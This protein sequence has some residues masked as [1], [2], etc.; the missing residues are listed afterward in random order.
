MQLPGPLLLLIGLLIRC[1]E[2][3]VK[4]QRA[5]LH[6]ATTAALNRSARLWLP[7]GP[8]MPLQCIDVRCRSSCAC[9]CS[10]WNTARQADRWDGAASIENAGMWSVKTRQRSGADGCVC[11]QQDLQ[12]L[13]QWSSADSQRQALHRAVF[14]YV[15]RTIRLT[16]LRMEKPPLQLPMPDSEDIRWQARHNCPG[17]RMLRCAALQLPCSDRNPAWICSSCVAPQSRCSQASTSRP[18]LS[19]LH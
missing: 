19:A 17:V 3:P 12:P 11:R 10:H 13:E 9:A 5:G 14:G 2:A 6:A 16:K 8:V 4:P 18:T 7:I 15:V 1:S